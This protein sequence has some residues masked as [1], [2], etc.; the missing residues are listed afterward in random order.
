MIRDGR[1]GSG[2]R[3][4]RIVDGLWTDDGGGGAYKEG[5]WDG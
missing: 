4:D 3:V 2:G 1:G 5:G